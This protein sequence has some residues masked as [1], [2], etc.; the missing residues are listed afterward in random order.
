MK[1]LLLI[2]MILLVA[3]NNVLSAKTNKK[4]QERIVCIDG[5]QYLNGD[6]GDGWGLLPL[7]KKCTNSTKGVKNGKK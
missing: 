6:V 4:P 1:K 5:M 2:G 7:N 3:G